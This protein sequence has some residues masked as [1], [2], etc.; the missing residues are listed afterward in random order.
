MS[1]LTHSL[2][3]TLCSSASLHLA[4]QRIAEAGA[5]VRMANCKDGEASAILVGLSRGWRPGEHSYIED[6]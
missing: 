5:A 3:S 1:I 4:I 2:A 6:R